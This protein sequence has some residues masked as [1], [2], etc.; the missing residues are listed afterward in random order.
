M[1]IAFCIPTTSRNTYNNSI[2]DTPLNS[3]LFKSLM[4]NHDCYDN[5]LNI[6]LYIGYDY[7]DRLFSIKENQSIL[8]EKYH[9]LNIHWIKVEVEPGYVTKVWNILANKAINNNM[10]YLYILGDDI[11]IDRTPFIK[12]WINQLKV[13]NNIGWIAGDNGNKNIPTQFFIHKTHHKI[14]SYIFPS[15]IKN[16]YCDN[17]L[18]MLYSPY[19]CKWLKEYKHLNKGGDPRYRP[20]EVT[21]SDIYKREVSKLNE[22]LI[23]S[24]LNRRFISR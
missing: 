21:L 5:E 12:E 16:W 3:I 19:Y 20:I 23:K 15:E 17:L 1:N 2:T 24:N 13:N 7:N 14:F 22:Y 8:N 6:H 10:D 11:H 4:N 18:C 9:F